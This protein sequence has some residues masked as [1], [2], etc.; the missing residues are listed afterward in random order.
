MMN[1]RD[2]SKP[3]VSTVKGGL[4]DIDREA[5][6]EGEAIRLLRTNTVQRRRDRQSTRERKTT[7]RIT[8]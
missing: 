6:R 3:F 2:Y 8:Q 4:D 5:A 7:E 1:K